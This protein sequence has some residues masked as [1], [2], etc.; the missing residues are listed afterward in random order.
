IR[1]QDYVNTCKFD[2]SDLNFTVSPAQPVLFDPNGGEIL[3][4]GTSKEVTWDATTFYSNVRLDYSL[5]NGASWVMI[6]SS[7][8]NYGY[9]YW[10]IPNVSSE[11][12]LLKASNT[13]NVSVNDVSDAVF[14]IK[15]AVTIITPNGD[16]D[17]TIWG[18]CTVTSITVD[19]SPAW[20]SYRIEYSLNNGASWNVVTSSWTTNANPATYNWNMPNASTGNALV[21]VIPNSA[22]SY[23]DVSDSVFTITKPVT[24]IQPNYG[25]TMEVGTT[26]NIM[27]ESDGISNIYDIFYSSNGGSSWTNI[28][29]GYN[30]STNTYPWLVPN[31][32][33]ANSLIRVRDNINNCKEDTSD[34]FFTI[35]TLPPAIT[36][37]SP[38]GNETIS[39]CAP[40]TITWTEVS[41][42]G[43][44]DLAYST[45]NGVSW[46]MIAD[47]YV[48]ASLSYDWNVP[49]I[50]SDH[51]LVRVSSSASSSVYDWSDALITIDK[52]RLTVSPSDTSVC[53]NMPVQLNV[54]GGTTYT[55]SPASGLSCTACD[56]PVATTGA[57]TDYA[58]ESDNGMCI[59]Y[60]T[61]RVTV[62]GNSSIVAGV[63]ITSSVSGDSICSGAAVTFTAVP[64]NEGPNPV[65][66]WKV[67]GNPVGT[68]STVYTTSALNQSDVVTVEMISNL[69]C[70]T[71]SPATSNSIAMTVATPLTP[72]VSFSALPGTTVCLGESIDF[73]A[74]PVNGGSMP[75]YQWIVNGSNV[76]TDSAGFQ[77][78]N[79]ANGDQ[80]KVVL[81]SNETCLASLTGT[82]VTQTITVNEIPDQPLAISGSATVCSSASQMYNVSTVSGATSYTWTL[83][84]GWSG[85]SSTNS[86]MATAGTSDGTI[87]VTA[88]N[89]CGSSMAQTLA[90]AIDN[91]PAQP[92]SISGE[93]DI[94]SG[95]SQTYDLTAVSG[96]TSYTW[97]LP[98]GWSGTSSTNSITA[99][100]GNTGGISVTADNACG[101]S[102]T[103]TLSVIVNS[104]PDQA[105]SISGAASICANSTETYSVS[106]DP[107]ALSYTWTLP[108]GWIGTSTTNSISV[109]AN[110]SG[111]TISVTADNA[112]GSSAA[113]SLAVTIDNIPAQPAL[114][115]GADIVCI[116]STEIYSVTAVPGVTYTWALPSG[117][118]G[119]SST[120]S[121]SATAGASGGTISVTA[122]NS[123][124]SS[125]VQ[126]LTVTTND[127][128]AQPGM[129]SGTT[130]VCSGSSE[131][132]SVTNDASATSY[133]WTL[134][135]GWTGTS[136][137][138]SISATAGST[139]G[140]IT[141]VAN[142]DCGS[143]APRIMGVTVNS[144]PAL[145]GTIS[146]T[147]T[148]CPASTES[149]GVA[150]DVNATSYTWTLPSGWSG[151]SSTN[152]ISATSGSTGGTIS[153]VANNS[154]GS[155]LT[156]TLN[157]TVNNVPAQPGTISGT[158]SLCAS[159]SQIYSVA[160]VAGATSYTWTLPS[161]WSGTSST[162]SINATAGAV[163]GTISVV[164]NNACGTSVARTLSVTVNTVPAQP[165][166]ISGDASM[167]AGTIENYSVA[168]VGGA[169]SYTWTL[170]LGWSGTSTTNSINA[171]AAN[172]GNIT[173]KANNGCGSSPLRTLAVTVNPLPDV[174][175]TLNDNVLTVASSAAVYQWLDCN[176]G[177]QP[178]S[179]ATAQSFTPPASGS[180]AVTVTKNGCSATSSC[181]PVFLVG[182]TAL[183][184]GGFTL[185]PNPGSG[186]FVVDFGKFLSGAELT[187]LDASG[188]LVYENKQVSGESLP[189]EM[190]VP[191]GVYFVHVYASGETT[192]LKLVKN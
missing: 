43:T 56:N 74:T 188:K 166:T 77:L 67:N 42:I 116:G 119:T 97:T 150:N 182:L 91:I 154:C 51:V 31:T 124:G 103:Q 151:T 34:M 105:V 80:V 46:T 130:P 23:F 114:I 89:A 68:N 55:W 175:V 88:D 26:Y 15:P 120:N 5:D 132:Y 157:V 49:N 133:T 137:T 180:Y 2:V 14:T 189:V 139:G 9:Y 144:V 122:D 58:V 147:A 73:T 52:L 136:T 161:G 106:A 33:S 118:S 90:I 190:N 113:Q 45:N 38:N 41:P 121:I 47:D 69:P 76:G 8:P 117:W 115:S 29:M 187:I 108:S 185:Y 54:S 3:Y 94:C 35:S 155:S 84:S 19:R 104:A 192:V 134:P 82:S 93:T 177:N 156:R 12:C 4:S 111:G 165:G 48:T 32:P 168:T 36:L 17:A 6:T 21:K 173:V 163:G 186:S 62:A 11:H 158:A 152:S 70:V 75:S 53:S 20:N 167:C 79:P 63:S 146:G 60:D 44:Y 143:S 164:A 141:V 159:S 129:I 135:S 50:Q 162:N 16:N 87:S 37:T 27:W 40:H 110:G 59:L 140:S 171:T 100:A 148:L 71:G 179:G 28:V 178:V 98:S 95:T 181:T 102:A 57:T 184:Q 142:N 25:G 125:G 39:G 72:A 96:A 123:C 64:S 172:S 160:T 128:P 99:T 131:L 81:T 85:T 92:L 107:D 30:T 191:A 61:V 65:Y 101:S 145:P 149:Y 176:N 138:N 78:T 24:I 170:P 169:T 126:S 66:Q 10:S 174:N 13:S 83:P 153:V 1:V 183:E 18:G 7:T 127:L 22:S 112:C 109:T 86:I